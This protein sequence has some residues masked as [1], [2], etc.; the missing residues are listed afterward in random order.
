MRAH[1]IRRTVL[2]CVATVSVTTLALALKPHSQPVTA[3]P[4]A[5]TSSH[6]PAVSG[7][8]GTG[9]GSGSATGK[10][11]LTGATVQTRYGPVQV[12]ITVEG[13]KITAARAVKTPSGDRRSQ[14]IAASSVPTL[15]QET[16][17]AQSARIDTVSGAT[18]TSEGY[19]TSLQSALDQA[20]G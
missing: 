19:M 12:E 6:S 8:S 3:A 13:A 17:D 7:G 4:P 10:R 11:T 14:D 1:P 5:P 18:F 2:T 15:V 20:R 16:L 9:S